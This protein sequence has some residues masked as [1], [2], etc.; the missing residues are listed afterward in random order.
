MYLLCTYLSVCIPFFQGLI[1]EYKFN[2]HGDSLIYNHNHF[3]PH[4]I[5]YIYILPFFFSRG[6][7]LQYILK[8]EGKKSHKKRSKDHEVT[9]P[10][11]QSVEEVCA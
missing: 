11:G 5:L 10:F 6:F 1:T 3:G 4:L 9:H 8:A 7:L 2:A